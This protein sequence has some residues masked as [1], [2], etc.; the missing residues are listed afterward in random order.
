M[1]REEVIAR[2]LTGIVRKQV[3]EALP[4]ARLSKFLAP[5]VINEVTV[6]PAPV[7]N[8]L[9]IQPAPVNNEVNVQPAQVTVNVDMAPV[10]A[11]V[12]GLTAAL[13]ELGK[14]IVEAIARQKSEIVVNVPKIVVPEIAIPKA[15]PVI[16][17][18][19]LPQPQQKKGRT[20]RI[21][22]RM[23]DGRVKTVEEIEDS[24]ESILED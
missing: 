15:D 24:D 18:V 21:S 2:A 19:T 17:N 3:G 7:T 13:M 6:Q 4:E 11:A 10:A 12:E 8:D 23:E 5:N 20:I 14:R 22:E 9:M 1:T 16:V